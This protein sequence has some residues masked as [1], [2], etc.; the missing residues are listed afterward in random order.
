MRART[1]KS[2]ADGLAA[3]QLREVF[4]LKLRF[5]VEKVG[6][7][8]AACALIGVNR[9]QFNR[10]L[11]GQSMPRPE[12][13]FQ[14]CEKLSLP[15]EWFFDPSEDFATSLSEHQFGKEM[16]QMVQGHLFRVSEE[17]MPDG[18]YLLWKGMF[19]APW[20]YECLLVQVCTVN[21]VKIMRL[22]LIRRLKAAGVLEK[23]ERDRLHINMMVMRS[24][25]GINLTSMEGKL[26][27]VRSIFVRPSAPGLVGG[28]TVSFLGAGIS[29]SFGGA[30]RSSLVPVMIEQVYPTTKEVLTAARS[31]RGYEESDL[32]PHIRAVLK[33]AEVPEFKLK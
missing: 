30:V 24:V 32:P 8:K 27:H 15:M 25:N 6:S 12:L 33:A 13:L 21:G 17:M 18:F 31:V 29:G 3:S 2:D 23:I 9:T 19:E 4:R 26:N 16:S 22:N 14:F 5:A 28:S 1:R 7:I 11:G 20:P 10:Y